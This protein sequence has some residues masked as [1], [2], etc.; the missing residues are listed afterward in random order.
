MVVRPYGWAI[1]ENIQSAL[2]KRFKET[3]HVNAAFPLFIPMSFM[4][5]EKNHV[6]GFSPELAVVTIGGGQELEEPLLSGQLQK[7]SSG[8]CMQNGSNPTVICQF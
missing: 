8:I 4:E 3:G 1:W 5:K 6:E 7:Q 2:D